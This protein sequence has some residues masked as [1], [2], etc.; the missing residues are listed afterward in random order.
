[1]LDGGRVYILL[2][3]DVER[4]G[5]QKWRGLSEAL[6]ARL[7]TIPADCCDPWHGPLAGQHH[8]VMMTNP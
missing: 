7:G 5:I 4:E 6:S 2:W 8:V 3:R 1:M